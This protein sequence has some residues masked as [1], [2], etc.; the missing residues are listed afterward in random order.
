VFSHPFFER[1]GCHANILTLWK[2]DTFRFLTL[3]LVD[4]VSGVTTD[5]QLITSLLYFPAQYQLAIFP[6]SVPACYISP[7]QFHLAIVPQLCTSFL[8]FPT[9][10]N[11][12]IFPLISTSFPQLSTSLLYFPNSVPA[13]Y[14][15][16][17]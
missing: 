17:A 6:S 12:A 1:S 2:V 8:Y 10:Y 11:L 9:Q 15:S 13:C 4:T 7:D 5:W 3:P 16:T 14:I